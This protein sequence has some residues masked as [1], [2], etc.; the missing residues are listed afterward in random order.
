MRIAIT[1]PSGFVGKQL[2]PL[3]CESDATLL[4]VGRDP[5]KLAAL[6][7]DLDTCDYSELRQKARGYDLLLN[8]T[9]LNNDQEGGWDD[10]KRVNVDLLLDTYSSAAAAGVKRFID[11]SSVRALDP[12]DRSFY[13]QSKREGTNTLAAATGPE[14]FTVYLPMVYSDRW[15]GSLAFLNKL[16]RPLAKLLFSAL[17][18]LKP[19][20]HIAALASLVTAGGPSEHRT[21]VSDGQ[22]RNPFFKIA[23]RTI[24]LA[25]ALA[26]TLFFWWLLALIWAAIR[27]TS[28]GPGLFTQERV[29][30]NGR[31]FT[32]Y[33]FRTMKVG[34]AQRGTHE[35]SAAAV[36]P[37]GAFLRR[38]KL[39]ELPQVWN[40]LRNEI[41]LIGPRPC[42]PVQTALVEAR[43]RRGVLALT[44]G[45]SGLAQINEIDMSDPE[46]LAEWDAQYAALQSLVLDLRIILATAGGGGHGDRVNAPQ[47]ATGKGMY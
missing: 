14:L 28:P 27:L 36:T 42:L 3:L 17:R 31:I 23:K 6:Y 40:I 22:R 19:T 35:I 32:C 47:P 21:V 33:K 41:S 38:T 15:T 2:V 7:P 39:D 44:P 45:I 4:L 8:L 37:L 30:R 29:G 46:L 9:T 43:Q 20:V 12:K 10:F 13:A 18:A 24:D 25:F 26:V 5:A 16:P 34:T 11:I 1:G